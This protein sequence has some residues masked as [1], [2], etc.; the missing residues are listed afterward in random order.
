MNGI[1]SFTQYKNEQSDKWA[2]ILHFSTKLSSNHTFC[3]SSIL[4]SAH[5]PQILDL[6]HNL[7]TYLAQHSPDPHCIP[8]F[9]V[10]LM[11]VLS[12]NVMSHNHVIKN[13]NC[14]NCSNGWG[15]SDHFSCAG[16]DPPVVTIYYLPQAGPPR[17]C[18]GQVVRWLDYPMNAVQRSTQWS[19]IKLYNIFKQM[20]YCTLQ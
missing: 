19:A 12:K 14:R 10:Y 2:C 5:T 16:E 6:I 17:C 11:K 15:Q 13:I 20:K 4:T 9:T 18:V 3:C 7:V 8:H 1:H